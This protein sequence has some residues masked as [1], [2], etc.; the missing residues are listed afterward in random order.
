MRILGISRGKRFSPN[1]SDKDMA[2]MNEVATELEQ[3][4]H[5][6]CFA[7]EDEDEKRLGSLLDG[8]YDAVFTML[9]SQNGINL[10]K[11]FEQQGTPTVN[12]STGITNAGRARVNRILSEAGI[13]M[14]K[15]LVIDYQEPVNID[16]LKEKLQNGFLLP[17]WIKNGEGWAQY[18]DDVTF[19]ETIPDVAEKIALLRGR[20]PY[21]SIV[22][23]E[24][25]CGDLVKFYGVE[26]TDFFFWRY[27]DPKN[28]KFGLEAING[29]PERFS[30]D[31]MTLKRT[32]DRAAAA[33]Q[34]VVY[35]GDC[36]IDAD[37]YFRIIDFNDWPS[38]STCRDEA[39]KAIAQ[40]IIKAAR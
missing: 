16:F 27:P 26:G 14:P 40:R 8:H 15:T 1:M 17:C 10:L 33:T 13:P 12:S 11:A 22:I 25:L 35:G 4:G 31:A 23:T 21:G 6:T 28:S 39:A 19:A 32:C 29:T 2:I 37:G 34:I 5:L 36:V 20:Y 24:H 9:R 18:A 7:D 3:L 38:F 30:F